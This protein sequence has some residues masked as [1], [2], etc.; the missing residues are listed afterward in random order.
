[1]DDYVDTADDN[2]GVHLNSGIPNRAFFLVADALGGHAWERAGRIWYD[3]LLGDLSPTATF[4]DFAAATAATASTRFGNASSEH[5]AVVDAWSTV[6]VPI[7]DT[8]TDG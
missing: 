7:G 2:G 8:G 5:R 4:A 3:A 1:M 6:G